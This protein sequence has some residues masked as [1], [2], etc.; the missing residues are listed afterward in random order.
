MVGLPLR[1]LLP[2]AAASLL[3]LAVGGWTLHASGSASGGD[4][5]SAF[6]VGS[7]YNA[8]GRRGILAR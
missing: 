5:E 2:Y 6:I 8:L 7:G 1:R 4:G 3:V